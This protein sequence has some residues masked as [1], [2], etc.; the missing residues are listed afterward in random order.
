MATEND[1]APGA[2]SLDAFTS[3]L[4]MFCFLFFAPA[5]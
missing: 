1:V 2:N 3:F 5:C 4:E